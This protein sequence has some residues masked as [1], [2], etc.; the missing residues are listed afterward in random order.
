MSVHLNSSEDLFMKRRAI[1]V[2]SERTGK[3]DIREKAIKL[4]LNSDLRQTRAISR[5]R[6]RQSSVRRKS[7]LRRSDDGQLPSP[8]SGDRASRSS[9]L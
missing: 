4:S 6:G 2:E 1:K 7:L 5:G 9:T 3:Y 8:A